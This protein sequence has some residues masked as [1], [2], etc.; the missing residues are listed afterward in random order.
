MVTKRPGQQN[1]VL[2]PAGIGLDLTFGALSNRR[3]H[4]PPQE[5]K[6]LIHVPGCAIKPE[7]VG[8]FEPDNFDTWV[9]NGSACSVGS[10]QIRQ[11]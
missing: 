6:T 10:P 7:K 8:R 3:L 1:T 11:V 2:V 4:V 5:A 9:S